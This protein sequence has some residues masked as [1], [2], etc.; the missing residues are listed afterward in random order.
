M[1]MWRWLIIGRAHWNSLTRWSCHSSWVWLL[2]SNYIFISYSWFLFC[3]S[4]MSTW[5][6]RTSSGKSTFS[7]GKRKISYH[8][9]PVIDR[10]PWCRNNRNKTKSLRCLCYELWN[11]TMLWWR[12]TTSWPHGA[13][14]CTARLLRKSAAG[15]S[16][17]PLYV[18]LAE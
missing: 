7:Q 6:I 5:A 3:I 13:T 10:K 14:Q 9:A 18:L 12:I 16:G 4:Q 15:F 11:V 2:S 17:M 8:E 1:H